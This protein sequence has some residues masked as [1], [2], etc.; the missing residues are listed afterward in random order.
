MKKKKTEDSAVIIGFGFGG[1]GGE[2]SWWTAAAAAA[3]VLL[4]PRRSSFCGLSRVEWNGREWDAA[5]QPRQM[6][7]A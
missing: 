2:V 5:E 7:S 1:F 3:E 4:Q 6:T